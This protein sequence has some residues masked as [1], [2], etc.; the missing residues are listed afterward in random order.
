VSSFEHPRRGQLEKVRKRLART[1]FVVVDEVSM[2]GC[3][4]LTCVDEKCSRIWPLSS[5]SS[6]VLGGLPIILFLGDFN[7]FPDT[8]LWKDKGVY[9]SHLYRSF[10]TELRP[11]G[12]GIPH[13]VYFTTVQVASRGTPKF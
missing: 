5:G 11:V 10:C 7:L 8:P 3:K 9:T 12:P 2:V 6:A 13:V 4:M 1:K